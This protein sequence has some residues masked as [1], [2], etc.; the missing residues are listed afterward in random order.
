MTLPTPQIHPEFPLWVLGYTGQDVYD[1]F[2]PKSFR[3]IYDPNRPTV[4]WRFGIHSDRLWRFEFVVRPDEDD[5]EMA[6]PESIKR[7]VW[8]FLTH[9]GNHYGLS[10][11]VMFPE[12]CVEVLRCRPYRFQARSCDRWSLGRVALLGDAAHVF[13]PCTCHPEVSRIDILMENMA[14]WNNN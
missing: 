3:F 2:F 4:C 6:K 13:P 8:P 7:A 10:E 1:L 14:N 5:A 9:R 11:D 12:D